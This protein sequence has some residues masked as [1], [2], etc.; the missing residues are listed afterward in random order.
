MINVT[1]GES[2]MFPRA[3]NMNDFENMFGQQLENLFTT[4]SAPTTAR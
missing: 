3:R 2:K 4:P 1:F